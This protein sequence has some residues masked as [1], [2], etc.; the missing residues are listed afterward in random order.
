MKNFF[1]RFEIILM[2]IG[3]FLVNIFFNLFLF[4]NQ[5]V[6]DQ[7]KVGAVW[8]EVQAYEWLTEKF[9][10]SLVSGQNPFGLIKNMLYPFGFYLG[11]V[12]AGNG[13]FFPL[14]KPFLSTHQ[15]MSIIIALSLLLANIGMYFLLRKL[16]I[17]KVIAFIIGAAFGYMTFLMPR[18]GHLTYWSHFVFPWFYFFVINFFT[19]K[20]N[21]RKIL[22]IVGSSFLF[23]LTLW[24]NFYYFVMLLISIFSL[25]IYLFIF[26][27][28]LFFQQLLKTWKYLLLKAILIFVFLSPWLMALY[29]MF[30]FDQ[31]PKI[32]GWGG[33]IE[34]ASDLFN[35]FIPSNYSYLFT[36]YPFLLKP[37]NLFLQLF[38]P[39]ARLIFENFTYPGVII[40]ASFF[41]LIVFYRKINKETKRNLWPFLFTS[42]VFFI[43][44]L[45]PFLHVFG[46]W[47][48]TVDEGIKIV[49]PLP[50]IILHH[51]PFLNNI[52]VPGRLIVGFIFFAYIVSAYLINYYLRNKTEKVKKIFFLVL[53]IVFILDQR[54]YVDPSAIPLNE[55]PYQIYNLIKKDH[56]KATVLEI[57][58]TVRD[59]FT[60]FGDGDAFQMIIGESIHQKPVLGGYTGRIANY[61]KAYYQNNPFLGFIGRVIDGDL[62][63]NPGIDKSDLLRWQN[64]DIEK[65]K[66]AI[67]FLDLKYIITNDERKYMAT[68]SAILNDLG[69]TKVNKDKFYSLWER[70]PDN[71]EFLNIDMK[72]PFSSTYLGFGWHDPEN[73]LRWADR[74]SSVMFKIDKLKRFNLNFKASAFYKDQQITIYLNKKKIARIDMTT[75]VKEYSIPINENFQP[76]INTVYFIFDRYYRPFDVISGSLDKR[77]LSGQFYQIYL[78]DN[79]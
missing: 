11:L 16:N 50:Y 39:N 10:Q 9:Y 73:G 18:G 44:T 71:R 7:S 24:L 46:H 49:I 4:W 52:R 59:G 72:D 45:G 41:F 66:E 19:S 58:F 31:V 40:L 56:D 57:P 77:Q 61:K 15:T 27:R 60:Y 64:I 38:T 54:Y 25:L 42:L 67:D 13:L 26:E 28:K 76:G 36:K 69:F 12:D 53:F 74:K 22:N 8:G 43:L 23:V 37:F 79:K 35:Y 20:N 75:D 6:F 65:S 21:L 17:S 70:L 78:A 34:F 33:A 68:L 48:L 29:E 3:Y 14:F 51:I 5:L 55:R 2:I 62:V 30:I 1:K 63:K 32:D 47:A